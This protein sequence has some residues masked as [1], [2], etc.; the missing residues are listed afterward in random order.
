MER[1]YTQFS[2]EQL[3]T[4]RQTLK[5]RLES[6]QE[7]L[8]N[9][10]TVD[11]VENRRI[12]RP[13]PN[14]LW[15]EKFNLK[16]LTGDAYFNKL[17]KDIIPVQLRLKRKSIP[18]FQAEVN[19]VNQESHI[20]TSTE[21]LNLIMEDPGFSVEQAMIP[22]L[23]ITPQ[24]ALEDLTHTV[25]ILV[26]RG[27][28]KKLDQKGTEVLGKIKILNDDEDDGYIS[29]KENLK[30]WFENSAPKNSTQ[31]VE[32]RK[33]TAV[34][35]EEELITLTNRII[36]LVPGATMNSWFGNKTLTPKQYQE[37]AINFAQL[38][39]QVKAEGGPSFNPMEIV[40]TPNTKRLEV[41]Q[42]AIRKILSQM[43]ITQPQK[44]LGEL[45]KRW[46]DKL[47]EL[48]DWLG[49][50]RRVRLVGSNSRN[51]KRPISEEVRELVVQAID[52]LPEV[53]RALVLETSSLTLL[54]DLGYLDLD[55]CSEEIFATY[56]RNAAFE[57]NLNDKDDSFE[58]L[59]FTAIERSN[60]GTL[61][62][63]HVIDVLIDPPYEPV[64]IREM[65]E[66]AKVR[67]FR[68]QLIDFFASHPSTYRLAHHLQTDLLEEDLDEE[69]L[70]YK[71][72]DFPFPY[73]R[74]KYR[75]Q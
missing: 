72:G 20:R 61:D 3:V 33:E 67:S 10:A 21:V 34:V 31:A 2:R 49:G 18:G 55:E 8:G 23:W 70:S 65:I 6:A 15:L 40:N 52:N 32:I 64:I 68:T 19:Q 13:N 58:Q 11:F 44:E 26:E 63:T 75:E 73:R 43:I 56:L 57:P 29:F 42:T 9:I 24:K 60:A 22:L 74:P 5:N 38:T 7:V 59:I 71:R 4:K 51:S 27:K 53:E 16:G 28:L 62:L 1:D 35:S 30:D 36:D 14:P 25:D 48:I 45:H 69:K 66:S 39:L 17:G 41:A 54:E 46:G 12:Q 50:G 47:R 37:Q